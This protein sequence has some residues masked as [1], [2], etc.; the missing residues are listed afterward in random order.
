MKNSIKKAWYSVNKESSNRTTI[1]IGFAIFLF[2]FWLISRDN[3]F[4]SGDMGIMGLM[5]DDMSNGNFY[6]WYFYGQNYFGNFEPFILVPLTF[7]TGNTINS[8]YFWEYFFYFVSITLLLCT[9]EKRS[10]FQTFFAYL[11]LI[12]GVQHIFPFTYFPQGFA[13]VSMIILGFYLLFNKILTGKI[14]VNKWQFAIVGFFSALSIWHN[15]LVAIIAP[16]FGI[17]IIGKLIDKSYELQL[18][19]VLFGIMGAVLGIIPFVLA[20]MQTGG[21]NLD[22]FVSNTDSNKLYSLYYVSRDFFFYFLNPSTIDQTN[23]F[24]LLQGVFLRPRNLAGFLFLIAAILLLAK[25]ITKNFKE[26]FTYI[27]F[28]AFL[29]LLLIVKDYAPNSHIF[30]HIRYA[31]PF[32][33]LLVFLIV[34]ISF[35]LL[36]N[37]DSGTLVRGMSLYC[38]MLL[39][40]LVPITIIKR[41]KTANTY[42]QFYENIFTAV[43]EKYDVQNLYCDN[44][45]D[46]CGTV[47]YLGK[48]LDFNVQMIDAV[49]SNV[50]R[51]PR[52]KYKVD[53]A[54]AS[55]KEILSLIRADK[56]R[57]EH[58][59]LEDF[60]MAP[61]AP[62][63]YLISGNYR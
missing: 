59:V 46:V 7:V 35:Q 9:W 29:L 53:D 60:A 39:F 55:G 61:G 17:I 33:S 23:W 34:Y 5:V 12:F 26:S 3:V 18:Q 2:S 22:W 50:E 4:F 8:L 32:Y 6:S 25:N 38:L 16:I 24:T 14:K 21:E 27:L 45:Y 43:T 1:L 19:D 56:L 20:T 36:K 63:Y 37:K 58:D 11:V 54:I 62:V 52:A 57:E 10:R 40:S 44:Y 48:D 28:F 49:D 41:Y 47:A 13:F 30:Y 15:L 51:N 42:S 31:V